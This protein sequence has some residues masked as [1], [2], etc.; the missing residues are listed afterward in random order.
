VGVA[1]VLLGCVVAIVVRT[2]TSSQNAAATETEYGA[3]EIPQNSTQSIF[4]DEQVLGVL[5]AAAPVVL[6]VMMRTASK[7]WPLIAAAAAGLYLFSRSDL[8]RVDPLPPVPRS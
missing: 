5:S 7:N 8:T 1:F 6:P 3:A 2:R 4:G